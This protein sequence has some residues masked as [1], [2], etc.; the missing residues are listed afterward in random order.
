MSTHAALPLMRTDISLKNAWSEWAPK[1]EDAAN[2]RTST[3]SLDGYGLAWALYSAE[4]FEALYGTPPRPRMDPGNAQ[5]NA[6][7]L[8]QWNDDKKAFTQQQVELIG[9]RDDLIRCVPD[10]LFKPMEVNRSVRSRSIEYMFTYFNLQLGTLTSLDLS[11]MYT[12]LIAM[13]VDPEPI[14]PF[15]ANKMQLFADYTRIQQPYSEV[16]KVEI[17]KA[18]FDPVVFEDCWISYARTNGT[19]QLQTAATLNDAV[20]LYIET[21]LPLRANKTK[22]GMSV[23]VA[24]EYQTQIDAIGHQLQDVLSALSA[25]QHVK[26]QKVKHPVSTGKTAQSNRT[27]VTPNMFPTSPFCWSHGPGYHA[28]D[29]CDKHRRFPNH[30]EQASWTKQMGS[31][32]RELFKG[33]GKAVI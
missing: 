30:K 27:P 6:V 22:L 15:L 26:N 7:Q 25:Q 19:L 16:A 29:C 12:R 28:S 3:T 14:A 4:Q 9:L 11:E 21:I 31:N 8:A 13:Y 33:Q 32:W 5:G 23:A 2:R 10:Y 24:V 18:C 1:F 17:L 20:I